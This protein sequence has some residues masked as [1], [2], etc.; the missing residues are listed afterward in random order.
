MIHTPVFT[1]HV[2]PTHSTAQSAPLAV[3]TPCGP[4][5]DRPH[6]AAKVLDA[7]AEPRDHCLALPR[8]ALALQ[9]L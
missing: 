1:P 4:H 8:D 2:L 7:A 5:P 6:L 9:E 3:H